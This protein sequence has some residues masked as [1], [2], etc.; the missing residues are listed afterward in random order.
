MVNLVIQK[1]ETDHE[2]V[3]M[4][5]TK[6]DKWRKT[7]LTPEQRSRD[8]W[9][10]NSEKSRRVSV[11][12]WWSFHFEWVWW[13]KGEKMCV[14]TTE[15]LCVSLYCLWGLFFLFNF[16]YQ[17]S[18]LKS[19]CDHSEELHSMKSKLM[20]Y[21]ELFWMHGRGPFFFEQKKL[22][23]LRMPKRLVPN[24]QCAF[25]EPWRVI[26]I[27]W[28]DVFVLAGTLVLVALQVAV[29]WIKFI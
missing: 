8:V 24:W 9:K 17:V 13:W 26:M 22:Y 21:D 25:S 28:V 27:V 1:Q 3:W 10:K 4:L 2:W 16:V 29:I 15:T 12:Q 19:Q 6:A 7:L 11:R 14:Q 5:V 18:M 20:L 23:F